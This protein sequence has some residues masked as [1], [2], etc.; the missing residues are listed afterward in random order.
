MPVRLSSNMAL[1]RDFIWLFG[2]S[3]VAILGEVLATTQYHRMEAKAK[4]CFF[5][6]Y[7]AHLFV[8]LQTKKN[9]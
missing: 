7:C 1:S 3:C 8:P 4:K 6:L 2:A 5:A 9:K